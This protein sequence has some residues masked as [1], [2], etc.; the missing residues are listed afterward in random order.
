MDVQ[1]CARYV[2]SLRHQCCL[3]IYSRKSIAD[4]NGA[5][6]VNRT[7]SVS[8]RAP[9]S[10][11]ERSSRSKHT[12]FPRTTDRD[13]SWAA[14]HSSGTQRGES[15]RPFSILQA[16]QGSR[17]RQREIRGHSRGLGFVV[18]YHVADLPSFVERTP[19]PTLRVRG[20]SLA[21]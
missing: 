1:V 21:P 7:R 10:K 17:V 15:K 4:S 5:C 8:A 11:G 16:K 13:V 20:I 19:T 6:M 9:R 14:W 18:E 2:T 12:R 3:M